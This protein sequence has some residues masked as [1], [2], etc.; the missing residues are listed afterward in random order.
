MA[1]NKTTRTTKSTKPAPM[2]RIEVKE[3]RIYLVPSLLES[4]VRSAIEL[5]DTEYLDEL[6][7]CMDD[8]E[9]ADQITTDSVVELKSKGGK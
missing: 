2:M 3:T 8:R 4:E 9:G 1:K 6:I 7:G 5:N